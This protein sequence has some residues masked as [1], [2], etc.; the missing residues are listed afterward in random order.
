MRQVS[1]LLAG[2]VAVGASAFTLVGAS[3]ADA[4]SSTT[5]VGAS[6]ADAASSTVYV[7]KHAHSEAPGRSCSTARYRH[8]NVAIAAAPRGGRVV[9]CGGTYKVQAVVTRPMSLIG[10]HGASSTP[11]ARSRSSASC[12]AAAASSC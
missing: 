8:I 5:L 1:R 12:R 9:V 6:A 3:A 4:A 11:R 7:S 2:L 10:R